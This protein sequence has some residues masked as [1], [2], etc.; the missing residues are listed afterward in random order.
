V[1]EEMKTSDT[2][3]PVWFALVV[4]AG[5]LATSCA[6]PTKVFKAAARKVQRSLATNGTREAA[7]AQNR[8]ET[9]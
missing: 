9:V 4:G 3:M 7:S 6:S 1:K 5:L 8:K 2:K